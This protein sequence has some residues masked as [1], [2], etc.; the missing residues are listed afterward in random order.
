[1]K[2]E[3]SFTAVDLF[4]GC[5]GLTLGLKNAG[6]SV[7]AAVDIDPLAN[8]TYKRNHP[9][10]RLYELDIR[11]LDPEQ[12][13]AD[14][15][16][17]PEELDLLAGGPP[18]Q[19]FSSIRTLNGAKK[20]DDPGN[21]LVLQFIRFAEALRPKAV[22]MEN[23]PG[24]AKDE[25]ILLVCS[26]FEEMGYH[27]DFNVCNAADYGVPQRRRRVILLA[28]RFGPVPVAPKEEK[29]KTV[30]DAIGHLPPPGGTGDR[31]HDLPEKRSRRVL[32][33]IKRIPKD[34]GSRLD[35][36]E[37]FQLACHKKCCGFK[38]VYGRMAW[39]DVAP[40]ITSGCVNPSKGRFLHPE[41]DRAITLREAALLQ[42]FPEDYYFPVERGKFPVAA[43]IGNALP[44]EFVRRFA[45]CI[46]EY[47][48]AAC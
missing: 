27:C 45:L 1:M 13:M 43:L 21:D 36:G 15:G 14:V 16:L 28:G 38:D 9:E 12:M 24:L 30:R 35:A 19:G 3:R 23:V 39:D 25:R 33:L 8:L 7:L 34:G 32:E 42:S 29:R 26:K 37:E 11:H 20:V 4:S 41:Q 44:P 17:R 47:L 31:L 2:R 6:F 18:C 48:T 46:R 22:L 10:V 5:G 40:T